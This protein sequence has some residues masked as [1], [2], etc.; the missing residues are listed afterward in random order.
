MI[1]KDENYLTTEQEK[2]ILSLP[3]EF[4]LDSLR[5]MLEKDETAMAF[6]LSKL[7]LDTPILEG[8]VATEI[9]DKIFKE[10]YD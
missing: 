3:L 7:L 5:E 9:I 4:K 6:S 1:K 10:Y 2:W 8:G